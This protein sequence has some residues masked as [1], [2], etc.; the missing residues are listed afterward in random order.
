MWIQDRP[1]G[2]H[3]GQHGSPT[4]RPSFFPFLPAVLHPL[5]SFNPVGVSV[6]T[7]PSQ[8]GQPEVLGT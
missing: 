4:L 2:G 3:P 8:P 7:S 5:P 1:T 6:L